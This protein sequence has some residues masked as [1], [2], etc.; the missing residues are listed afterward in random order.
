MLAT[1]FEDAES[2][3]DVG[4]A[5]GRRRVTACGRAR[6]CGRAID[7]KRGAK[8][9]DGKAMWGDSPELELGQTKMNPGRAKPIR[10]KI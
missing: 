5:I 9:R 3:Y 6:R 4:A 1:V 2:E 10:V 7:L 8:S